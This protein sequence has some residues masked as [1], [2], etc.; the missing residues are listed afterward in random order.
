MTQSANALI[1]GAGGQDGV[2]LTRLLMARG[3][4][5]FGVSRSE[6]SQRRAQAL[7]PGSHTTILDI[8]DGLRLEA[9][10][11]QMP[12]DVVFNLAGL[13]SVAD[14]WNNPVLA[15]ET[16]ALAAARVL[17]I[18]HRK[19]ERTGAP[20][21][22]YQ[23]SSSEMFGESAQSGEALSESSPMAPVSPYGVAKKSAHDLVRMYRE[24]YG[25]HFV[26]GILFNHESV[27]RPER[28]VFRRIS[29]RVAEI[30]SN[31]ADHLEIV[32]PDI[33]R[34]WGDARDFV[35]AIADM[36]LALD[37][38]DYV[39]ATGQPR[40]VLDVALLALEVAGVEGG[41]DRI[42]VSP[43][44]R[45]PKD[46]DVI[47]GNASRIADELDWR[48]QYTLEDTLREMVRA[49]LYRVRGHVVDF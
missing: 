40:K 43:E 14:C 42:R 13:S 21:R 20:I 31:R 19:I 11:Q 44:P 16:N 18:V 45:R 9:L 12:F 8:T 3:F 36:T 24:S 35:R 25:H 49:D 47:V 29:K 30:A 17:E 26:S 32:S 10:L 7:C 6:A 41:R 33:V 15:M 22:L 46:P 5:C 34:D 37:A 4:T 1:L 28:F 48:P 39:V 27:F 23:A 38:R 2:L